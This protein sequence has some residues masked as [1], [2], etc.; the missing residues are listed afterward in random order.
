M[1]QQKIWESGVLSREIMKR[2]TMFHSFDVTENL[3]YIAFYSKHWARFIRF[4]S[5]PCPIIN[6]SGFQLYSNILIS[7]ADHAYSFKFNI[8]DKVLNQNRRIQHS[9]VSREYIIEAKTGSIHELPNNVSNKKGEHLHVL[10]PIMEIILMLR[11]NSTK[12]SWIKNSKTCLLL[13]L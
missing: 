13:Q 11:K 9:A 1:L 2:E 3:F 6:F 12:I 7:T 4:N 10:F 8:V 5:F